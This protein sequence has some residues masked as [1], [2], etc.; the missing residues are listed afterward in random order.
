MTPQQR[1]IGGAV[2]GESWYASSV[3]WWPAI[4]DQLTASGQPW[5]REAQLQDLRW[6]AD[7]ERRGVAERP[8]RPTLAARW[9]TT[10]Y[11]VRMALK[12]EEWLSPLSKHAHEK[13][14]GGRVL[15]LDSRSTAD[16]Q[17][18]ASGSTARKRSNADTAAD[19]DSRSTANGQ[20]ADS[21]SPY[22]RAPQS[23][24]SERTESSPPTPAP[25][26][27]GHDPGELGD[28][29]PLV[30][31][32]ERL[33]ERQPPPDSIHGPIRARNELTLKDVRTR[34]RKAGLLPVGVKL[35]DIADAAPVALDRWLARPPPTRPAPAEPT[36][37]PE[38]PPPPIDP[39]VQGAWAR[40][41]HALGEHVRPED[42]DIWFRD[43]RPRWSG[44]RF[45]VRAANAAYGSWIEE[46]YLDK[47]RLAARA[48]FDS[49]DVTVTWGA[50][51]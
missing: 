8:G 48:A 16:G 47:M 39:A 22:A 19:S 45:E 33:F 31:A 20:R 21:G 1:R 11:A 15:R 38:L 7:A 35:R 30:A 14:A 13:P 26:E 4:A 23:G 12:S 9:N 42:I 27:R 36:P 51:S 46:N 43:A 49:D 50:T 18:V 41:L 3:D 24:Q 10:D 44:R 29:Q 5:S 6:W 28:E 40:F 32:I 2:R 17:P 37:E 25:R 34:L